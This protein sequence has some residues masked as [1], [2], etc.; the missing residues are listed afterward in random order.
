MYVISACLS[1][2]HLLSIIFPFLLYWDL[3]SSLFLLLD[4]LSVSYYLCLINY[5]EGKRG[6]TRT[7]EKGR[8]DPE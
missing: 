2:F 8:E 3:S 4:W 6:K 5:R 1:C 7:E